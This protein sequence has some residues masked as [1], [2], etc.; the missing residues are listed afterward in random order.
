LIKKSIIS[1]VSIALVY[2]LMLP[3]TF[4]E[5]TT[6]FA[7]AAAVGVR[8]ENVIYIPWVENHSFSGMVLV[9][10]GEFQMGCNPAHNGGY[11]CSPYEVPLHAVYLDAYYID[12][13]EVANAQYAECVAIGVCSAPVNDSSQTRPWYFSNP[14]YANYPVIWVSWFNAHDYCQWSG[15]RLP[16][17][18]E[19]EKAARGGS[20][21]RAYPWGN[22][23]PDCSLVNSYA[24]G[25]YCVGDTSQV[26]SYPLGASPYGVLDM[27][28]NVSEW[29]NDWWQADYYSISPYNNPQGP[30]SGSSGVFRGGGWMVGGIEL[31]VAFRNS[32]ARDSRY[33]TGIR[34]ASDYQP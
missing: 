12:R 13:T 34:C 2:S 17:E 32:N 22:G 5:R 8:Q 3:M 28:G 23:Q 9:P 27:A 25:Q 19:W 4:S 30:V 21:L 31:R 14:D 7:E 33:Y 20:D 24:T 1:M 15:K 18:A 29:V 6:S 26:G 16:S 11:P 10:A